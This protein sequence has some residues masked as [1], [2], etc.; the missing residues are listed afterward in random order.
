MTERTHYKRDWHR[1]KFGSLPLDRVRTCAFPGCAGEFFSAHTHQ[2]FCSK[3]CAERLRWYR[4]CPRPFPVR[5]C[6]ECDR[7]FSNR[8]SDAIYCSAR[9]TNLQRKHR[10][11]DTLAE[12]AAAYRRIMATMGGKE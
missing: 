3:R 4:R 7:V 10:Y 6:P 9:C 2:K 12:Q 8:R 11:R 5:S 1:K